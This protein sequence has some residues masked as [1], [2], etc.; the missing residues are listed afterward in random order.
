ML[1]KTN[2]E[3]NWYQ[4]NIDR[5]RKIWDGSTF[6]EDIRY[7][8]D[9]E[10]YFGGNMATPSCIYKDPFDRIWIGSTNYG[11]CMYDIHLDKFFNYNTRNTPLLSDYITAFSYDPY[12]GKLYIGTNKGLNSVEIGKEIKTTE[13]LGKIAVYPNPFYP[14]KDGV[15]TLK[16]TAAETMPVGKNKCRIFDLNGNLVTELEESRFFEFEWD[17][18]NNNGRKCS[19]GLYMY[20][21]QTEKGSRTGKIALIR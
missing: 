15:L 8:V 21:I 17:G 3:T 19:S 4:Y 6:V 13:E 12:S 18:S 20:L 10:R 7:I 14:E 11:I 2:T 16:N 5:K 9:E 1:E